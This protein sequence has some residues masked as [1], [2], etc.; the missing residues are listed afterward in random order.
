[1]ITLS[2]RKRFTVKSDCGGCIHFDIS[3]NCPAFPEGIPENLLL[4]FEKHRE[5]RSDQVGEYVFE[6]ILEG[7]KLK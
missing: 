7:K 4:N 2:G 1:M 5:V 3:L 6:S